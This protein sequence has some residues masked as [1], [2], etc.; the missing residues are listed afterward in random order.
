MKISA[1]AALIAVLSTFAAY[2]MQAGGAAAV[3]AAKSAA[4]AQ[5][6][7]VTETAVLRRL[8][9]PDC[10]AITARSWLATADRATPVTITAAAVRRCQ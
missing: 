7:S 1:L 10:R 9:M 3:S 8:T 2:A 5:R 4:R 6:Q